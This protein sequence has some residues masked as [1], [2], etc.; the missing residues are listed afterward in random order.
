MTQKRFNHVFLH[1][2]K[3]RTDQIDI[4]EIAKQFSLRNHRR[5]FFGNLSL[6]RHTPV[7]VFFLVYYAN[8]IGSMVVQFFIFVLQCMHK[9]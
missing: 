1:G 2:H 7:T 8:T 3:H 9:W 4:I 5:Q 6:F